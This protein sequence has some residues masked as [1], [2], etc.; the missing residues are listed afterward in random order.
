MV[1]L[2]IVKSKSYSSTVFL[3]CTSSLFQVLRPGKVSSSHG[4][5]LLKMLGKEVS[6][7]TIFETVL[8]ARNL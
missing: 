1:K 6:G 4:I 5:H 2:I 8:H 3:C 7:V